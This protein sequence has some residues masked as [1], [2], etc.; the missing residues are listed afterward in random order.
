VPSK[1]C[2]ENIKK[3]TWIWPRLY[4][5]R[6][7]NCFHEEFVPLKLKHLDCCQFDQRLT[8]RFCHFDRKTFRDDGHVLF[9]RGWQGS[10]PDVQALLGPRPGRIPS[11]NGSSQ[12]CFWPEKPEKPEKPEPIG[13]GDPLLW[14]KTSPEQVTMKLF[15]LS[16]N[17]PW[18]ELSL[19][20]YL[21]VKK[22]TLLNCLLINIS[23]W[24]VS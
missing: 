1:L 24:K 23:L 21:S 17:W 8:F 16:T 6:K 11:S 4:L 7:T 12:I 3:L 22:A 2:S 15:Y 20:N 9:F 13:K 19:V 14:V 10:R 5:K 18:D